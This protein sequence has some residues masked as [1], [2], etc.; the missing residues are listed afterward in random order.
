MILSEVNFLVSYCGKVGGV[1]SGVSRVAMTACL[2]IG[3]RRFDLWQCHS[4]LPCLWQCLRSRGDF[5]QCGSSPVSVPGHVPSGALGWSKEPRVT[6]QRQSSA[7]L[8]SK[9]VPDSELF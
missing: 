3:E 2:T 8:S 9:S 1:L 7:M 5:R 6:W 4:N